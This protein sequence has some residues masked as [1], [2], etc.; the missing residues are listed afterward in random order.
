MRRG[1][2]EPMNTQPMPTRDLVLRLCDE[3]TEL[4]QGWLASGEKVAVPVPV[5]AV[6]VGGPPRADLARA[7]VGAARTMGADELLVCRTRAEHMYEPVERVA[8]RADDL[9]R[10]VGAWGDQP[11]ETLYALP[12]LSAAVLVTT[13]GIMLVAGPVPFVQAI[14]GPDITAAKEQFGEY[15]LRRRDDV[16]LRQLAEQYGCLEPAGNGARHAR[17][18]GVPRADTAERLART[19]DRLREDNP[20]LTGAFRLVRTF[21]AW[22]AVVLLIVVTASVDGTSRAIPVVLGLGWLL[23]QLCVLC[24]SRT[25]TLAVCLRVVVLGALVCLPTVLAERLALGAMGVTATDPIAAVQ[26]GAP[27][28]EIAKLVPV[29]CVWWFA[30]RRFRRLAA[31]DYVLLAAASGAGFQLVENTVLMLVSSGS[32]N[33]VG[34]PRFAFF[35]LLPGWTDGVDIRFAGHAVLT[36]LVGACAGLAAV[37]SRRYG[38]KLWLLPAAALGLVIFDHLAFDAVLS[39]LHL[40]SG[41]DAAYALIGH[42][43]LIRPLFLLALVACV[44]FDHR[45]FRAVDDVVPPLPGTPRWI[46]LERLARGVG[47][48]IR[49]RVP[50]EAAPVFHR[51]AGALAGLVV[52]FAEATVRIWHEWAVLLVALGRGA[53]ALPSALRFLR[54]RRELAMGAYR[55]AGRPRRDVPPRAEVRRMAES[56][57]GA[58]GLAAGLAC[59]VVITRA[60]VAP[61]YGSAFLAA[62]VDPLIA[63]LGRHPPAQQALTES[64][65]VALLVLLLCGWTIADVRAPGRDSFLRDPRSSVTAVVRDLTPGRIPYLLLWLAGLAVPARVDV[66]LTSPAPQTPVPVS[67]GPDQR[68]PAP[69]GDAALVITAPHGPGGGPLPDE[70]WEFPKPALDRALKHATEFGLMPGTSFD[71]PA[72]RAALLGFVV[73][74]ANQRMDITFAGRAARAVVDR[75][76]GRVVVFTPSG[77]FVT[78]LTLTEAQ[79][80]I[81]LAEHQL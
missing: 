46:A 29:W 9:A 65:G 1:R 33:L 67:P 2:M 53:P 75:S 18:A 56:V 39:G 34:F 3:P 43:H 71:A 59:A 51:M 17:D 50:H 49:A 55:A 6:H 26:V 32:A 40:V 77:E 35:Q 19:A 58:L 48:R 60:A 81:L 15:A 78:C 47:I 12:D 23:V 69:P 7:V 11:E 5:P 14:V 36:G 24:R 25:V 30:R 68:G 13:G 10:T 41:T 31:V 21:V 27:L 79:L 45:A 4:N 64:G 63:W 22:A 16:G 74:A 38:R 73:E 44:L 66:L 80:A 8:A 62:Y 20:G 54:D 52:T 61:P 37:G 70:T 76:R 28:E 72:L 57:T 42:G